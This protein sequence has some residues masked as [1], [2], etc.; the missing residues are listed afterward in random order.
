MPENKLKGGY[1]IK[2]HQP[3][4]CSPDSDTSNGS[5]LD[6]KLIMKIAKILNKKKKISIDLSQSTEDIHNEILE[7][8]NNMYDCKSESCI[9]SLKDILK[10]LGDDKK[11]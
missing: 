6:D 11:K 5:C 8:M 1:R 9:L 2:M 10:K 7:I 4:H 3:K